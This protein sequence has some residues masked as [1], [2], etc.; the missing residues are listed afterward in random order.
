MQHL[1]LVLEAFWWAW[2]ESTT[3]I[4]GSPEYVAQF[5]QIWERFIAER[6]PEEAR[7]LRMLDV[8]AYLDQ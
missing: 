6:P 4:Y 7:L 8:D 2:D 5:K 1:D 3:G